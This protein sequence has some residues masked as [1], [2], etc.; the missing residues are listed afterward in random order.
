MIRLIRT[1]R[2][3]RIVMTKPFAVDEP[4]CAVLAD[5]YDA[6]FRRVT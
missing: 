2:S 3:P 4:I 6:S 1:A 5:F